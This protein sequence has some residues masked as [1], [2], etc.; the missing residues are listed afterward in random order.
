MTGALVPN[1]S[2]A[3]TQGQA[4][5]RH[6]RKPNADWEKHFCAVCGSP[7]PG[8]NDAVRTYLPVGLITDGAEALRVKAHIFTGS[9]SPWFD[10]ADGAARHDGPL[11]D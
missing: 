7:L 9:K 1:A 11:T 4:Q 3:R 8:P 6:W 5:I 2:F 10:I